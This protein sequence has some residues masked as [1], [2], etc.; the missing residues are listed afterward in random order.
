MYVMYSIF[1]N[2]RAPTTWVIECSYFSAVFSDF[3]TFASPGGGGITGRFKEAKTAINRRDYVTAVKFLKT[4]ADNGY[5]LA[6]VSAM[7]RRGTCTAE[8]GHPVSGGG[9]VILLGGVGD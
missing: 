9:G 2:T 5:V 1:W 3:L 6:Q 8:I 4:A 7:M